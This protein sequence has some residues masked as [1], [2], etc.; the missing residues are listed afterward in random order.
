MAQSYLITGGAGFI[1]SHLV[2]SIRERGDHVRVLDNFST[3][4]RAN[5]YR[6]LTE[7][8][9]NVEL[10]EGDIRDRSV[11]RSAVRGMD[12]V[13]HHA[14]MAS[15]TGSILAP[16]ECVAI[17]LLGTANLL[18]E[19][20]ESGTSKRFVFASSSAVYG[21]LSDEP[22]TEESPVDPRSPYATTKLAAEY[23]C[24]NYF[25]IHGLETVCLR[26]FNVY[27]DG[28]DPNGPYAAVIP[29]FIDAVRDGRAPNVYGDGMQTR[30][31][32][33]VKDV[34]RANLAAC[35]MDYSVSSWHV[36][37]IGCG[38]AISLNELIE[39]LAVVSGTIIEPAYL[40]SAPGDVRHSLADI[41]RA[42]KFLNFEPSVSLTDGLRDLFG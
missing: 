30:D 25:D 32:V 12:F 36:F 31:F 33:S 27:G 4:S 10:L 18:M 2:Q 39:T 13:L 11:C 19:C 20:A 41:S 23:L 16:D 8:P 28:Q 14:G 24:R 7:S 9:E 37:N 42:K 1:G 40:P 38:R 21:D 17:N 5:L 35:D 6:S 15:V 22:K 26:Y 34:V 29:K 3:G